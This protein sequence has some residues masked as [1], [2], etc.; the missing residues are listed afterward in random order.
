[1]IL[2]IFGLFP[3]KKIGLNSNPII[4]RFLVLELH[5]FWLYK[6]DDMKGGKPKYRWYGREVNQNS[7]KLEGE[8]TLIFAIWCHE[9][10][11]SKNLQ[12]TGSESK[13]IF[14]EG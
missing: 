1:M 7:L 11:K 9:G 4:W 2:T 14:L 6:I 10:P 5:K 13:Q 12:I 3:V 8:N